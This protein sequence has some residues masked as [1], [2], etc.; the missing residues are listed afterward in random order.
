MFFIWNS[1]ARRQTF[2]SW[3]LFAASLL[4]ATPLAAQNNQRLLDLADSLISEDQFAAADSALQ[5][6]RAQLN[7]SPNHAEWLQLQV[8][9]GD[10]HLSQQQALKAIEAYAPLKTAALPEDESIALMVAK[11]INDLGIAYEKT[12]QTDSA[13]SAHWQSLK[14]YEKYNDLQGVSYNYN[15]LAILA[16]ERRE[17]NKA[18]E[19]HQLSLEAC[20]ANHDSIGIGFNNLNMGILYA[21]T[22][23]HIKALDH[24]QQAIRV[25]EALDRPNWVM[26]ANVILSGFYRRLQ[27]WDK[28]LT[29]LNTAQVYYQ[30]DDRP[31]DLGRVLEDKAEIFC[32]RKQWDSVEVY[33]NMALPI[34]E[35]LQDIKGLSGLYFIQSELLRHQGKVAEAEATL[36][37]LIALAEG[38][39]VGEASNA[40]IALAEIHLDRGENREAIRLALEANE[41]T[42]GDGSWSLVVGINKVLTQAYES[43]GDYKQALKYEHN[44][45]VAKDSAFNRE[46][47]MSLARLEYTSLLEKEHAL[48]EMEQTRVALLHQQ[49]LQRQQ[50]IT[51][52]ALGGTVLLVALL[53]TAYRSIRQRRHDNELLREKNLVIEATNEELNAQNE[54][55]ERMHDRERR[56]QEREK[57]LLQQNISSKERELAAITM[58]NHEQST[59]LSHL[60]TRLSELSG[61]VGEEEQTKIKALN[62]TIKSNLN[63]RDS[64]D[65]FLHRFEDVHPEFFNR[66]KGKNENLTLNDL[67]LSAYIKIG[68]SNKEIAQVT[69]LEVASVKRNINRLKK[70]LE[71][72]AEDSIRDFIMGV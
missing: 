4:T 59:V 7:S 60:N 30:Q 41:Q 29:I 53:F 18:L 37:K 47:A 26:M 16:K 28:A 61:Q 46:T 42:H 25:F 64:W 66:L 12:G 19:Y 62:K 43:L 39:Y 72:G 56:Q 63:L 36:L 27:D 70:K 54:E 22:R 3:L 5:H 13:I 71:L 40:R 55:L 51:Y 11:G 9:Y 15:N 10:F 20:V 49:E 48:A 58:M 31:R 14:I 50:W 32:N 24:M 23:R 67:K 65:S 17:T 8:L 2:W 57:A 69:N 68:M 21:D 52:S 35:P 45:A 38:K 34:L 44:R 33:V 1:I 6:V